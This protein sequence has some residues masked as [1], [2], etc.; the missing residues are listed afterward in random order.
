VREKME[1][2]FGHDFAN[3]RVHHGGEAESIG[4]AAYTRGA[5]LHFAPGLYQP[6]T[7]AGQKLLG[8]ELTHVVQQRAG[9][10]AR[11]L[12]DVPINADPAL[13]READSAGARAAAGRPAMAASADASRPGGVTPAVAGIQPRAVGAGP[14]IQRSWRRR[15]AAAASASASPAV[16]RYGLGSTSLRSSSVLSSPASSSALSPSASSSR[17]AT[18]SRGYASRSTPRSSG[19]SQHL[20]TTFNQLPVVSGLAARARTPN[21]ASA[22]IVDRALKENLDFTSKVSSRKISGDE[23]VPYKEGGE[24]VLDQE[25]AEHLDTAIEAAADKDPDSGAIRH[26]V[27]KPLIAAAAPH[28]AS[29]ADALS[30]GEAGKVAFHARNTAIDLTRSLASPASRILLETRDDYKYGVG[31]RKDIGKFRKAAESRKG[32]QTDDD[33]NRD[34]LRSFKSSNPRIDAAAKKEKETQ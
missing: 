27:Y 21:S 30:L 7:P 17:W 20:T 18:P 10:V 25:H 1:L 9:R 14:I 23:Y 4:A 3:V 34:L 28:V 13:E 24:P 26:G 33:F 22:Q 32:A 6:H 15:A 11:P 19:V 12:A 5:H 2:S 8:H 16:A 29:A 31:G